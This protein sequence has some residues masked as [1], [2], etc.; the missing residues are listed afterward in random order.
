MHQRSSTRVASHRRHSPPTVVQTRILLSVVVLILAACD[1]F[2]GSAV[3]PVRLHVE[4]QVSY[5]TAGPAA[6]RLVVL[7]DYRGG[8]NSFML[9]AVD[10]THDAGYYFL[11]AHSRDGYVNCDGTRVA[12]SEATDF[13]SLQF[14]DAPKKGVACVRS[15]QRVDFVIPDPASP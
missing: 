9:L 10:R 11:E 3:D 5:E 13:L 2:T 1:L 6:G 7:Y 15:T 4:G 14:G 12:V 8:G